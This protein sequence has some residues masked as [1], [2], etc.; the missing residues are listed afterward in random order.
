MKAAN[1]V[2]I[3]ELKRIGYLIVLILIFSLLFLV[4]T[5]GFALAAE[6]FSDGFESGNFNAWDNGGAYLATRV[7]GAGY[8][9]NGSYGAQFAVS[10]DGSNN[11]YAYVQD[12]FTV[13]ASKQVWM[14]AWVQFPGSFDANGMNVPGE[15]AVMMLEQSG[16][17]IAWLVIEQDGDNGNPA[18]R[19]GLRERDAVQWDDEINVGNEIVLDPDNWY[20]ITL[21]YDWSGTYPVI[22]WFLDGASQASYTDTSTGSTW[23]PTWSPAMAT[24][25]RLWA[26]CR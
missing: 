13:P 7:V 20:E 10:Q 24:M 21:K 16:T 19:A 1:K 18:L 25:R 8:A 2:K 23:G 11:W 22:E 17:P 26:W 5:G 4:G 6:I 9:K 12:Q 14:K 15:H 3:K